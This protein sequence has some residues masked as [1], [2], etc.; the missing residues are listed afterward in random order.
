MTKTEPVSIGLNGE[1]T[2]RAD[3]GV[4]LDGVWPNSERSYDTY[5]S[6]DGET[7]YHSPAESNAASTFEQHEAASGGRVL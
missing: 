1:V 3:D 4:L 2:V 5:I 6:V 7:R